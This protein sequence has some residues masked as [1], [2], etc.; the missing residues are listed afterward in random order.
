MLV[1]DF[2]S[3][4]ATPMNRI[5]R[6]FAATGSID[7]SFNPGTGADSYVNSIALSLFSEEGDLPT[8]QLVVTKYVIGGGFSSYNGQPRNG[9]ARIDANA[10]DRNRNVESA[11]LGIELGG[12]RRAPTAPDREV[13]ADDFVHIGHRSVDDPGLEAAYRRRIG[14]HAAPAG[15]PVVARAVDQQDIGR[16]QG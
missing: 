1:G 15:M 5:G 13:I 8:E 9:I 16:P 3:I 14:D 7:E 10:A 12:N 6:I 2:T 4:S 11:G